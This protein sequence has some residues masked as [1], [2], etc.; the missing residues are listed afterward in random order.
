MA[1]PVWG[2][3][4]SAL[5]INHEGATS[6]APGAQQDHAACF[7]GLQRNGISNQVPG[8]WPQRQEHGP[9]SKGSSLPNVG[10]LRCKKYFGAA[11]RAPRLQVWFYLLFLT[12]SKNNSGRGRALLTQLVVGVTLKMPTG[13]GNGVRLQE[14]VLSLS[15]TNQAINYSSAVS[16][17]GGN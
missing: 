8:D 14:A 10:L 2:Q 17:S 13:C 7:C 6:L 15:E 4:G 12:D 3:R 1:V 5:G 11:Q 9:R 16:C